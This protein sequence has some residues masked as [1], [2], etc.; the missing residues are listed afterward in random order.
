METFGKRTK[1]EK[2]VNLGT[3]TGYQSTENNVMIGGICSN[4]VSVID[5]CYNR[6]VI[7]LN[8]TNETFNETPNAAGII[9]QCK[10]RTRF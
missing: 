7:T 9:G 4:S 8:V 2:C 3:I 1:I 5:S 6:G 10:I